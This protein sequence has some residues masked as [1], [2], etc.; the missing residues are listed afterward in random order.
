MES[1]PANRTFDVIL[2]SVAT[3]TLNCCSF[4]E[5]DEATSAPS[6][7]LIRCKGCKWQGKSLRGHL[8]RAESHCEAFYDMKVLEGEAKEVQRQKRVEWKMKNKEKIAERKAKLREST[9]GKKII[10]R[11]SSSATLNLKEEDL[12]QDPLTFVDRKEGWRVEC[13]EC[14]KSYSSQFSLNR[15]MAADHLGLRYECEECPVTFPRDGA[16][17]YHNIYNLN[18]Y[19]IIQSGH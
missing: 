17:E 18:F 6:K 19:L 13:A 4:S 10:K 9:K 2:V 12:P 7:Q 8:R 16:L 15:H 5:T 1:T 14:G 3:A 11:I